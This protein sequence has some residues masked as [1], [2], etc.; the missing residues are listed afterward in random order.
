[1]MGSKK[2][3][4]KSFLN[5]YLPIAVLTV[6]YWQIL[7]NVVWIVDYDFYYWFRGLMLLPE[8][9]VPFG[10]LLGIAIFALF[11]MPVKKKIVVSLLVAFGMS[12]YAFWY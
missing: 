12:F 3:G 6:I 8:Y 9:G 11:K 10:I 5:W 4:L 2:D 7:K 1:M